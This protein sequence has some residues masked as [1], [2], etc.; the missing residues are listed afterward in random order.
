MDLFNLRPRS[1]VFGRYT[2][3]E[4]L[5][6]GSISN[7]LWRARDIQTQSD[8]V[9]KFPKETDTQTE[10]EAAI[11]SKIKDDGVLP[12]VDVIESECGV[13]IVFPYAAGG[14]CRD[15]L[16]SCGGMKES[17]AK[18]LIYQLLKALAY[19][20]ENHVCHRD[21]KLENILLM[22]HGIT[23]DNVRLGDFGFAATIVNGLVRGQ[24]VDSLQYWAPELWNSTHH[25]EKV[26][27]WA[28]GVIMFLCLTFRYPKMAENFD[29]LAKPSDEYNLLSKTGIFECGEVGPPISRSAV[30]LL[31]K[32]LN[33][34]PK[35]RISA[36]D[37]IRDTWFSVCYNDIEGEAANHT[38][39][40]VLT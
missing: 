3:T 31:K 7:Y 28:V 10:T 16:D 37:A 33:P 5:A 14:D 22:S 13:V 29:D 30:D 23:A 18:K 26:D 15:H 27:I 12:L 36:N 20:H 38:A 11:L 34:D 4:R 21:I 17:E 2:L 19:L 9:I 40:P 24:P 8:V 6:D 1:I 25:D 35:N 39:E 32:L